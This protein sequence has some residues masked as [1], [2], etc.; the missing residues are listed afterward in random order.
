MFGAFL[1]SETQAL[2]LKMFRVLE[3]QILSRE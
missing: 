3:I 2:K 1:V